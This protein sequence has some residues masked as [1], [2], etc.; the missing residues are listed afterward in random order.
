MSS[1]ALVT[2]LVPNYRTPELTRLC[3]RLLRKHTPPGRI[4]VIAID[5]DSR[6][7]ST[8]YLRALGWITVIERE[9]VA[10][11]RPW[12]AHA[13]ALDLALDRVATPYVLSIHTDT[14]VRDPAWLDVLLAPLE[15]D[16]MVA[17]VGSWKL[18]A[19]GRAWWRRALKAAER[20]AQLAL[21][22][23]L[24]RGVGKIEGHGDNYLYLRSHCAMYR[25]EPLRRHGLRFAEGDLP[26]GKALHRRL[27][28]L[29]YRLVFLETEELAGHVLHVNNATMVLNREFGGTRRFRDRGMRRIEQALALVDAKAVLA[30]EALDA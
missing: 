30:D 18:E 3:L 21:L 12:V 2:V 6:D 20:R 13:K 1:G 11:E 5:N 26:A 27:E 10:G 19:E 22:P 14:L 9:R 16:P 25:T 15:G 7:E 29:G 17:G 28:R 4:D 23:L 8:D 24:G